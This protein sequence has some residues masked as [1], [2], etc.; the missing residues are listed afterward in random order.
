MGEFGI[1]RV[2]ADVDPTSEAVAEAESERL[3]PHAIPPQRMTKCRRCGTPIARAHAL[4]G[5]CQGCFD[6]YDD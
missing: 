2:P 6:R 4:S 3:Q 5:M 1:G